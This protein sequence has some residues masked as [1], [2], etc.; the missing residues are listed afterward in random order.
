MDEVISDDVADIKVKVLIGERAVPIK[1]NIKML[2]IKK[3]W[4]IESAKLS[5]I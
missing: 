4:Y 3:K 1:A 5:L 2:Y